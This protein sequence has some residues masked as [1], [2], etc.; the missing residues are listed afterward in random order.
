MT[1]R[2]TP[3][4]SPRYALR[5]TERLR[6]LGTF[7]RD[8]SGEVE[9][10]RDVDQV[11][12][13]LEWPDVSDGEYTDALTI[14]GHVLELVATPDERVIVRVTETV[15]TARLR[16]LAQAAAGRAGLPADLDPASVWRAALPPPR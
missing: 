13:R 8:G 11:Q 1:A 12:A 10:F 14:D 4:S 2:C 7:V 9:T 6:G 3:S 15:D 16:T 5:A